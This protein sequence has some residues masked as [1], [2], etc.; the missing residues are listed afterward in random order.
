MRTGGTLPEGEKR[1]YAFGPVSKVGAKGKTKVEPP[2]HNATARGR[3]LH[4]WFKRISKSQTPSGES[5][6]EGTPSRSPERKSDSSVKMELDANTIPV[7]GLSEPPGTGP[8]PRCV[9]LG[10]ICVRAIGKTGPLSV[11]IEC[12]RI[13]MKCQDGDQRSRQRAAARS[14]VRGEP[15]SP[16]PVRARSRSVRRQSSSQSSKSPSVVKQRSPRVVMSHVLL[17]KPQPNAPQRQVPPLVDVPQ[18]N[19]EAMQLRN[20]EDRMRGMEDRMRGMEDRMRG[21]EDKVRYMEYKMRCME[22]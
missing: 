10:K 13:K 12:K 22:E 7:A 9:R 3:P 20:M 15:R 18:T 11:C 8:C 17:P 2:T 19:W 4:R 6:S 5:T 16:S 14:G 21:A 1:Q